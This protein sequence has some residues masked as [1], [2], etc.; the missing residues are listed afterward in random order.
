[1]LHDLNL[2]ARFS[3]HLI[4]LGPNGLVAAGTPDEVVTEGNLEIAFGLKAL[5]MPD[6]VTG[7][8]MVVPC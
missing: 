6:P 2:A 8:P 4:L 3:D 7:R 1:V 5:V